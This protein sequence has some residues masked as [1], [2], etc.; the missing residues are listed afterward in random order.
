MKNTKGGELN[1]STNHIKQTAKK[2]II[3][4]FLGWEERDRK[5]INKISKIQHARYS[6]KQAKINHVGLQWEFN[7]HKDG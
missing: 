3:K 1:L 6:L 4:T 2:I 5:G 7:N